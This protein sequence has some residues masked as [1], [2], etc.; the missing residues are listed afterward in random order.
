METFHS[1]RRNVKKPQAWASTKSFFVFI[2]N[3]FSFFFCFCFFLSPH[4]FPT[5]QAATIWS[6][7]H[8]L[9]MCPQEASRSIWCG[10]F[11]QYPYLEDMSTNNALKFILQD[12]LA[13]LQLLGHCERLLLPI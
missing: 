5:Q 11:R 1:R 3:L 13:A 4:L 9:S 8:M 10:A 12:Y 7:A 6:E 2:S